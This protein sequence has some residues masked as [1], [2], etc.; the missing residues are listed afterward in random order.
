MTVAAERIKLSTTRSPIWS[1]VIAAMLS[2]GIAALQP[3]A[4]L[5]DEPLPPERAAVGVVTFA[6]PVLMILAAMT[7]TGEYRSGMIR[8]TFMATPHRSRVLGAKAL[9]TA[10]FAG[11]S[12]AGMVIASLLVA[13]ALANGQVGAR[14]PLTHAEAWRPV[15]AVGLYA[16]LGAV[17]AVGLAVLL[18]YAAAV[19]AVLLLMPFVIEPLL[20][21]MPRIGEHVGP[22]LPFA[23]A[24]AF[25]GVPWFGAFPPSWGPLGSLLYF[26]VV[27]AAIYLAAVFVI[28]RRDP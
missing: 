25:T 9:I 14:L 5:S 27:V 19:I 16:A 18:R 6:V 13:R 21:S 20:G 12:A 4:T 17:L 3:A 26:T 28:N 15:G 7:I 10:V 22:L 24:W 8:T 11:V 2:L 1:A 23:N